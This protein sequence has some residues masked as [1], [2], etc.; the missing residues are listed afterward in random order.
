LLSLVAEMADQ[1]REVSHLLL[2]EIL[3]L[4]AAVAVQ[5]D[6]EQAIHFL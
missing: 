5:V 1:L 4:L 2:M 3:I 6:S